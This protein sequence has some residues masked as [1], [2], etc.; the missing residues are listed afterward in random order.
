MDLISFSTDQLFG[1]P[2]ASLIAGKSDVIQRIRKNPLYTAFQ[3]S[4]FVIDALHLVIDQYRNHQTD[5]ISTVWMIQRNS[6][7]I[8]ARAIDFTEGIDAEISAGESYIG[9]G[10]IPTWLVILHGDAQ[11]WDGYLRRNHPPILIRTE[12][13]QAAIDLRT[14]FP[15]EEIFLRKAI[16]ARD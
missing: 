15:E 12:N 4:V 10:H 13:N 7:E 1:G 9:N 8:K 14:V 3:S 5:E 2:Q 6:N 11:E 16:Q